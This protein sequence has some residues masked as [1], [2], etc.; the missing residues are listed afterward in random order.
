[1]ALSL[2]HD[3]LVGIE[4]SSGLDGLGIEFR[5][6]RDFLPSRRGKT[7]GFGVNHLSPSSDEFKERVYLYVSSPAV[8]SWHVVG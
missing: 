3:G 5:W 1:M 6:R 8:P 7:A 4:T 2:D